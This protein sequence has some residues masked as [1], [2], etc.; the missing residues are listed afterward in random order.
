MVSA[1][2]AGRCDCGAGWSTFSGHL[3]GCPRNT[4]AGAVRVRIEREDRDAREEAFGSRRG[5][6]ISG[7]FVP[8]DEAPTDAE[9]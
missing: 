5:I 6:R 1:S 7:M 3:P 2:N 9:L 8:E 4:Y